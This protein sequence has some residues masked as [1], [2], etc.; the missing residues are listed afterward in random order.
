MFASMFA[1]LLDR[2]LLGG[3]RVYRNLML[4]P[5]LLKDGPLSSVEPMSLE[6]ALA[7]HTIQVTEVSAEGHVPELRVKNSGKI[8]VLILDGEELVGAKQ[9]RIVNV[10]ILVPPRS[11]IVIPVSCIEAGRWGYSRPGF[12]AAGRVLNQEIRYG[13]AEAVTRSLKERHHRSSDQHLI[14]KGVDKMLSALGTASPTN[15]LS[16]GFEASANAIADYFT[17]FT[18]QPG[19]I[20]VIYKIDGVLAGLDLFGSEGS[21][22]RA[23]PKLVRGSAL[24]ALAGY[25]NEGCA[26]LHERDFLNAALSA[27]AQR[28]PAVG[29]G[30]ELR[31]DTDGIGGGALQLDGNLVHLFAY[32]RLTGGGFGPR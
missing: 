31:I 2:L 25:R 9:N 8:P 30:E 6:E 3:P 1:T 5:I 11:E 7:A 26:S 12:A 23:Y 13:K 19:Q 15:A 18:V 16:D 24:Q 4:T 28:F 17:A 22:A 14:W 21:F 20:G 29:L 10:T 27:P 32:P